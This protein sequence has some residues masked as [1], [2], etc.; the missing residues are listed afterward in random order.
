MIHHRISPK[1][2]SANQTTNINHSAQKALP[3]VV[4]R[5]R[6]FNQTST[7]LAIGSTHHYLRKHPK[8]FFFKEDKSAGSSESLVIHKKG[9]CL[10]GF[11]PPLQLQPPRSLPDLVC[12]TST[13]CS[14]CPPQK[15]HPAVSV[16]KKHQVASCLAVAC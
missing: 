3:L 14:Q 13:E 16:F 11:Q 12:W 6:L 9:S 7:Y 10:V 1:K 2:I 5:N 4:F 8:V 15:D